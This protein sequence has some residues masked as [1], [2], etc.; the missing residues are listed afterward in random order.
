M[1]NKN[2]GRRVSHLS[3]KLEEH[4]NLNTVKRLAVEVLV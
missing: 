4:K 2:L 3:P 1:L